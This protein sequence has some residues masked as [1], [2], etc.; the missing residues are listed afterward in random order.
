MDDREAFEDEL[1]VIDLWRLERIQKAK[2]HLAAWFGARDVPLVEGEAYPACS[3]DGELY[4]GTPLV[5]DDP[6]FCGNAM[7]FGSCAICNEKTRF[8]MTQ[9]NIVVLKK[10]ALK[11]ICKRNEIGFSEEAFKSMNAIALEVL[12]A[13]TEHAKLGK[14]KT[15][16]SQDFKPYHIKD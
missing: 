4:P 14:R 6:C 15:I 7:G 10:S 1:S 9:E 13:A 11:E 16:K 3:I 8:T 12:V 5:L 2:Y